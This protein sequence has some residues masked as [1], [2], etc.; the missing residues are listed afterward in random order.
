VPFLEVTDSVPAL[1]ARRKIYAA[2]D[3]SCSCP[4]LAGLSCLL[5]AICLCCMEI[6]KPTLS[7]F[8]A[9]MRVFWF[10]LASTFFP[11]VGLLALPFF[12]FRMCCFC[13]RIIASPIEFFPNSSCLVR[14]C[15][16]LAHQGP[17]PPQRF[18]CPFDK[19][20]YVRLL[21]DSPLSHL[22]PLLTPSSPVGLCEGL[23]LSLPAGIALFPTL[24]SLAFF[25]RK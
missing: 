3:F 1:S 17:F 2:Y 10:F 7:C 20:W 24:A 11:R 18:Q 25:S 16:P 12:V 21:L 9:V 19:R 14:L 23:R 15:P 6:E 8:L 22:A 5:P 13:P 4:F